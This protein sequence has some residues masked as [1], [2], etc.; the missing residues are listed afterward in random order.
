MAIKTLSLPTCFSASSVQTS[1]LTTSWCFLAEWELGWPHVWGETWFHLYEDEFFKTNWGGSVAGCRLQTCMWPYFFPCLKWYIL[2]QVNHSS[3][4]MC[5][6]VVFIS[7]G[8]PSWA[9]QWVS[10]P[11]LAWTL[12][13]DTRMQPIEIV[14]AF[15]ANATYFICFC[16]NRTLE[17]VLGGKKTW[18]MFVE[19]VAWGP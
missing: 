9:Q 2:Q 16:K 7:P 12:V 10:A 6:S 19:H 5:R 18:G 14:Y 8:S 15:I 13:P 1:T 11:S 3:S 4:L 17:N